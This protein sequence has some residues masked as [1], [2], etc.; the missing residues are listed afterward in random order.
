MRLQSKDRRLQRANRSKS[1]LTVRIANLESVEFPEA[2]RL[3]AD[4]SKRLQAMTCYSNTKLLRLQVTLDQSTTQVAWLKNQLSQSHRRKYLEKMRSLRRQSH[5]RPNQSRTS[6]ELL[7]LNLFCRGVYTPAAR[8]L[9][10]MLVKAGCS[11]QAIGLIISDVA[12]GAGLAVNGQMSCRTVQRC[13]IEGGVAAH[14][15]LGHE[16][17]HVDSRSFCDI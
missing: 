1:V 3:A 8:A 6:K 16:L 12:K 17:S 14:V 10:R 13:L 4:A 5:M 9:A 2:R 11:Q 7:R 15:Q